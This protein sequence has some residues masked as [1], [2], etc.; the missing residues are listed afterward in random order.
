MAARHPVD[1][2]DVPQ[3]PG[4]LLDVGFQV[5]FGVAV[6]AVAFDLLV[7]LGAKEPRRGPDAVGTGFLQHRL[8]QGR[9]PGECAALHEVGGDGD[10]APGF[11]G[12]LLDGA[13]TLPHL[14]LDVPEKGQELLDALL[15]TVDLAAFDQQ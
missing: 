13:H 5:V 3:S 7:P 12:A 9:I 2:L 6:A 14:E 4:R 10:V 15:V 1:H 8:A 11:L